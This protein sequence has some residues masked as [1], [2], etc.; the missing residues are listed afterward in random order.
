MAQRGRNGGVGIVSPRSVGPA[1]RIVGVL[2]V[3][4]STM[5]V[6]SCQPE[7]QGAP[8]G[9]NGHS[10]QRG[11][12][13]LPADDPTPATRITVAPADNMVD[14]PLDAVV[15]VAASG[16][17]LTRVRVAE[18]GGENVRGELSG[19]K[20]GWTS[21]DVLAPDTVYRIQAAAVNAMG[22]ST[23]VVQTFSTVKP[24]K[25]LSAE[26]TP[27]PG[28]TVGVAMP[29]DVK[30]NL[31]VKNKAAVERRL[32]VQTSRS[33]V[34]RWHWFDDQNV[35]FRP[36]KYWPAHTRVKVTADLRGVRSGTGAWGVE[37]KTRSFRIANSV[38]T[39]VNLADHHARVYVDG[40]LARTIPVTGG[41]PGWRTRDGIKVIL[42]KQQ[43]ITFTDEQIGAAENY[44]LFSKYGLRVTWSGEFLHTASWSTGSQGYAN[45]SHGCV[46]MNYANS[47]WLWNVSH[48]GD[49]VEVHSPEGNQ[50][51]PSN[52][53]GD[54]N[55]SWS[56]W[57]AGSAL[58]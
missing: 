24:S 36:K 15:E 53:Y 21:A 57:R 9:S 3:A 26:I 17:T 29:I 5:A 27:L 32:D 20:S 19:R 42:E 46:G 56:E 37:S 43:N 48:V 1:V 50:M 11:V 25:T 58:G 45:V 40:R 8:L 30:F 52:G 51:E 44:R 18:A 22:E 33:V 13:V 55:F 16:G 2:G 47:E 4:L 14:V 35:R 54:W 7:I 31:P 34:G 39:K 10:Y 49:P 38:V 6:V 28:T 12:G 23:E 41:M